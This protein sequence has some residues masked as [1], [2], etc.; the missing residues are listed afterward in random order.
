M[1][2]LFL[3]LITLIF[4][5]LFN[6]PLFIGLTIILWSSYLYYNRKNLCNDY[7]LCIKD[8]EKTVYESS[9]LFIII[10]SVILLV[11][12]FT[13]YNLDFYINKFVIS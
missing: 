1:L 5:K 2:D 6:I 10:I 12:K 9:I 13:K 3:L 8:I 7:G 4:Y 11:S